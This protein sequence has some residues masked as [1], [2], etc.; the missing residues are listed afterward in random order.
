MC[1]G[2]KQQTPPCS[3]GP[4]L[5]SRGAQCY[6][7]DE[8]PYNV[9][10]CPEKT[11]LRQHAFTED[12][13][14]TTTHSESPPQQADSDLIM[15]SIKGQ[16]VLI[17]GGSSGIGFAVADLCLA[18]NM[19]VHI[20]SSNGDKI[21][22]AAD[23]LKATHPSAKVT[24]HVCKLGGS[25]NEAVLQKTLEEC[26][27]DGTPNSTAAGKLDHIIVTAGDANIVPMAQVTQEILERGAS[28][29]MISAVLLAK[30]APSYLKPH[31]TS[32]LIFTGGAVAEKPMPGYTY[33]S[34][35]AGGLHPFVRALAVELK[36]VRV[37]M[38]APGATET[39][40]WGPAGG[41]MREMIKKRMEGS[42]LLGKVGRPEEVAEAYGYLMR[43]TNATGN[44]ISSNGGI[45]CQ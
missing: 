29:R 19:T 44:N 11:R 22:A 43:D 7:H 10:S 5:D 42:A 13:Q 23:R 36:P 8:A 21:A 28:M 32:S 9:S 27:A 31:W 37:N 14:P 4:E 34:F 17:I 6:D 15:P 35:L 3:I 33:P 39:E 25:D 18:E 24:T 38:V 41:E 45:T 12:D 2:D 30:L 40:L 16:N 1:I 20:A 26:T